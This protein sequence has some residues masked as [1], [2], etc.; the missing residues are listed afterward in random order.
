MFAWSPTHLKTCLDPR[1]QPGVICRHR[2][3]RWPQ[4]DKHQ[5]AHIQPRSSTVTHPHARLRGMYRHPARWQ[6]E[7]A[8]GTRHILWHNAAGLAVTSPVRQKMTG[9]FGRHL[10]S[11]MKRPHMHRVWTK[12]CDRPA[13]TSAWNVSAP[14]T[15]ANHVLSAEMST[16]S[17][18][19]DVTARM[20]ARS[21]SGTPLNR[22]ITRTLHSNSTRV[23]CQGSKWYRVAVTA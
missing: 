16:P 11:S 4:A 3:C 22:S 20:D 12:H 10:N 14:S 21:V 18:S 23:T 2:W 17:G 5:S 1:W 13:C 9:V 15:L 6:T 19:F 8:L 7:S